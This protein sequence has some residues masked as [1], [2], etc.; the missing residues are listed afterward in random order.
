MTAMELAFTLEEYKQRLTN[1]KQNM[2][3]HNINTVYITS[4]ENIYY[5][6]G[7]VKVVPG[8]SWPIGIAVNKDADN[9][10][11][12]C[13]EDEEILLRRASVATEAYFFGTEWGGGKDPYHVIITP[14]K[15][16][17]WL[18]G[19][20][21]VE[22]W[23]WYPSHEGFEQLVSGFE[24]AG[25]KVMD[26]STVINDIR[27]I[28]S[29]QELAY[30]RQA[31]K[32]ADIGMR[33][34]QK[35]IRPG[36]TELDVLAEIESA[37]Y[38]AGGERP[39]IMTMVQ[40]GLRSV[41][42]HGVATQRVIMEGDIVQ[43]DFCGVYKRYHADLGRT[44]CL[45][46]PPKRV[47]DVMRKAAG[48]LEVVQ[49]AVKPGTP[50]SEVKRLSEEYYKSVGVTPWYAAGYTLGIGFEPSW[51]GVYF[52][53]KGYNFDPGVV[54]NFDHCFV[55]EKESLGTNVIDTLLMTESGIERLS[56]IQRDIIIV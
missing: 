41:L 17:G 13:E 8:G 39:A 10:I 7:Y 6:T 54:T 25:A 5:F 2:K 28:K 49:K 42:Q 23:T 22:K 33:A 53:T 51:A 1:L 50:L 26:A 14:L 31:G 24:G 16:K 52:H 38:H 45:G 29:S 37:M 12:F 18:K 3:K 56:N 30:I 11:T 21:G 47:A 43:V 36:V 20:I 44:F 55:F 34:A 32:I 35:A 4:P 19:R 40:S 46:D 48:A 9:F 15:K 27:W